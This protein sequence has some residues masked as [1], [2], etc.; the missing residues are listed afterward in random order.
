MRLLAILALVS[1]AHAASPEDAYLA[2]RDKAI[3]QL[4]ALPA[5]ARAEAIQTAAL[6]ALQK[7]LMALIGRSSVKGFSPSPRIN[8]ETLRD[9]PGFGMLDGLA[10]APAGKGQEG[11]RLVATTKSLLAIWL[12]ARAAE[13]DASVRVS[14][15]M[16]TALRSDTFYTFAVG[17]DAAFSRAA[18]IEVAK[19]VGADF[20]V[21]ALGRWSQDIGP[22]P[23][24]RLVVAVVKG[25]R[26][27]VADVEPAAKAPEFPACK[28]IWDAANAEAGKIIEAYQKGGAK[29]DALFDKSTKSQQQ[30]EE[31]W[32]A[33]AGRAVKAAP[34]YPRLK[35]EAQD[36]VERMAGG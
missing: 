35:S 24:D 9:E 21:A 10:Y 18:E 2:A 12:R 32:L 13:S 34:F 8:L 30:G 6:A 33:C 29:D 19:P 17:Q 11:S 26:V 16:E 31:R 14:A 20:A 22:S 27:F 15:Q 1:A 36:L 23:L 5:D 7:R 28:A 25:G 3:A 4:K